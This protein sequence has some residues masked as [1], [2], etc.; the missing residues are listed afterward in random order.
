MTMMCLVGKAKYLGDDGITN[1]DEV[2]LDPFRKQT[3][4][5]ESRNSRPR[6]LEPLCCKTTTS[7]PTELGD[8]GKFS[9]KLFR[10]KY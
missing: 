3:W 10:D 8:T 2:S 4:Q 7:L 9:V 6:G 1:G 5:N